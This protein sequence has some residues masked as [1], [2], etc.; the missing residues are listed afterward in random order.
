MRGDK[1][2]DHDAAAAVL[3][4]R[5]R[6]GPLTITATGSSM[7]PII[8]DGAEVRLQSR[9]RPRR[10]EVWCY[11]A[12]DG[13]VVVHRVLAV[14]ATHV[15]LRGDANPGNDLAVPV[16]RLVGRVTGVVGGRRLGGVDRA[17][18]LLRQLARRLAGPRRRR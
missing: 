11:V 4:E 13:R 10:G 15:T 14:G 17:R 1:P 18:A 16:E 12:A 7:L 3:R 8:A 5:L 9:S 2:D 6:S